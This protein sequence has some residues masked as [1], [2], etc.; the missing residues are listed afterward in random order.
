MVLAGQ[1][2]LPRRAV[3]GGHLPLHEEPDVRQA[4]VVVLGEELRG[5]REVLRAGHDEQRDRPPVPLRQ[6]DHLLGVDLEQGLA[7]HG[8][9]RVGPLRP[10]EPEP[11][12]RPARDDHDADLALAQRGLADGG[13]VAPGDA[14]AIGPGE[15]IDG[16]RLDLVRLE[17][18]FPL[19]EVA[20]QLG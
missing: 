4:E 9:D 17:S 11:G 15:A 10:L 18:G 12:A 7:R 13:D 8:G 1:E 16:D 5:R 2:D 14:L 20:K 19:A 6:G 3:D